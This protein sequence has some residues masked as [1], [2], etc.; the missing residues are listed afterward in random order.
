M[1]VVTIAGGGFHRG[2]DYGREQ[3]GAIA[4]AA[5]ALK[6]HLARTG[7]PP[8][9]L[10]RRVMSGPL[11][12]VAADLTPDLWAEVRAVADG[13][14]VPAEDVLLLTFLDEVWGLG[15]G[16]GCS[17]AARTIPGRSGTPPTPPTTEIGQTMDLPS[18]ALGRALILRVGAE[19]APNALLLS[20]PGSIGLCGANDAGLGV[21]VTA[22]S[23]VPV[24]ESGLGVAFVVRHLLTLATLADAEAFLRSVPHAAGQTYTIAA[25]DGIATFEA[26]PSGVERVTAPGATS[27]AQT[28]HRRAPEAGTPPRESSAARLDLLMAGMD[29]GASMAELLTGDLVVDGEKW[30][31]RHVTFG[32]FRAVGS[33]SHVR[34]VDG[35]DLA[36]GRAE[37]SRI[38]FH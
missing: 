23:D 16:H 13:S 5:T 34:F 3:A 26:D 25:T 17:V 12:E 11:S 27:I 10:A 14:H 4:E 29:S 36:R 33:E 21:A 18:W 9:A 7:H 28:N 15:R 37:W 2:L 35:A 30:S 19:H 22:L 32:A 1:R 38:G 8:A 6:T 20:Y 31:D 24:S